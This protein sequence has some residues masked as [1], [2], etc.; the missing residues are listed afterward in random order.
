MQ[1]NV[2]IPEIDKELMRWLARPEVIKILQYL[3]AMEDY[4]KRVMDISIELNILQSTVT[5]MIIYFKKRGIVRES[6]CGQSAYLAPDRLKVNMLLD[7]LEILL[8]FE[9][10]EN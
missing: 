8:K 6:K 1:K 7:A 2:G 3:S 4:D 5:K 9:N 10:M